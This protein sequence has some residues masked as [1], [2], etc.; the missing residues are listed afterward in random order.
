MF[1]HWKRLTWKASLL[2][3]VVSLLAFSVALAASGDLDTTFDGDGLVTSYVVPSNPSR[4]DLAYGIAIQPNGKIVAA[5]SSYSSTSS[6]DFALTRYN[7]NG[8]LDTTFSGDGRLVTNLGGREQAFDVAIQANGKIVLAG[9]KCNTTGLCDAALV[10]Y[11]PN[12]TLDTTFSGDGKVVTDFGG[13]DNIA[14]GVAIQS[15]G[16]IVA[17]GYASNDFAIYRYNTNGSLD[18]TFSAD[19][20]AIGNFGL[21]RYDSAKDLAIQSDGKIVVVGYSF[22]TNFQNAD[23]AIARLN[24]NGT[25]DTT[26]SG[27]GRQIT[28]FGADEWAYGVALQ[29]DGKIVVVGQKYTVSTSYVA[30]A[31]YNTNGSADTTFNSSGKKVLSAIAGTESW[32]EDVIVQPNGKIVVLSSMTYDGTNYNFAL[33]RLNP[34][35][36]F[37]T[38]FSGDGKVI[39]DFGGDDNSSALALQPLD[40]NYLLAGSTRATREQPSDFALARVLP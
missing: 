4:D 28:N 29:T 38:T 8:A 5:G 36:S 2:A 21:D 37:D 9:Q 23:F 27:D 3:T 1:T 25:A 40:G 12:G 11:N 39:I 16:K 15:D 10:R 35:G 26:F 7:T 32:A 14:Y 6:D 34:S 20:I 22:D 19:G 30:V 24:A 31:R 18:T 17:V 13:K 33:V